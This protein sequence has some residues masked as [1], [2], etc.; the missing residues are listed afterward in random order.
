M[1]VD[2]FVRLTA[3]K[4]ADLAS[5][6]PGKGASLVALPHGG[7]L[8]D[9][10]GTVRDAVFATAT[11]SV[12]AAHA[13][14]LATGKTRILVNGLDWVADGSLT[15]FALPIEFLGGATCSANGFLLTFTQGFRADDYAAV[16]SPADAALLR[17][18]AWQRL[19][20]FHFGAKA[21]FVSA[22]TPGT[23]DGPA[24][25]AWAS[26]L[27]TRFMPAGRYGTTQTIHWNGN[28]PA[29]VNF[30][31]QCDPQAMIFQRTDN[32]PVMT[33]YGSR[34]EWDFPIL[35]YATSQSTSNFGAVGLLIAPY[36]GT[37]G[38]Y[39]NIIGRIM[40]R[41]GANTGFFNPPAFA[42]TLV[43]TA[44][45]NATSAIVAHAQTDALGG[46]PWV[47]GMWVQLQLDTGSWR[48]TRCTSVTSASFATTL[49]AG[50]ATSATSIQ[51]TNATGWTTG[52]G[53]LITLDTGATFTT[54]ITSVAG[55]TIGLATALP[56]AAAATRVAVAGQT[57][58]GFNSALPSAAAAGRPIQ[59]TSLSSPS[60]MPSAI[61]SN[62][63]HNV[64]IDQPTRYGFIDRGTGTGDA[65]AQMYVRT[66]GTPGDVSTPPVTIERAV[67]I[68]G[69]RASSITQF[70]IEYLGF[71][72]DAVFLSGDH[73]KLGEVH[74]EGCRSYG[75][76]TGLISGTVTDM[77][78][79]LLQVEYW[80]AFTADIATS[81]GIMCP[82]SASGSAL[83][84]TRGQWRIRQLHTAKNI[85][86]NAPPGGRA[87]LV[88]AA[89]SA[90]LTQVKIDTWRYDRD[91]GF[92]PTGQLCT[93]SNQAGLVSISNLL[94]PDCVAF[95]FDLDASSDSAANYQ[96]IY[97]SPKGQ[98]KVREVLAFHPSV[99]LTTASCGVFA[100]N[101]GTTLISS[102][103]NQAL[104]ALTDT[105]KVLSIPLASAEATTLRA[106]A[107]DM[108]FKTNV[109][110]N[111]PAAVTGSS[112]YLTGR[113][114]GGGNTNLA[115]VNFA[116]PHGFNVGD[117][118]FISGS[119]NTALS[120]GKRKIVDVPST[121]QITVY[122][123]SAVA[124]G[125]AAAPVA[126]AAIT[127][128]R[129]PTVH[130]VVTGTD[131]GH[132]NAC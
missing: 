48:I 38:W 89:S 111:K 50:A 102:V 4:T 121:T 88:R 60:T 47:P 78:I 87:F 75:D 13:L 7:T 93:N 77:D 41:G 95:A 54:T 31:M 52:Q 74:I 66:S 101:T 17:L 122:C 35:E 94:P 117:V 58:L 27:C 127:V 42:S 82:R 19:T 39:Q 62:T 119:V 44:A 14:A 2:A 67:Y 33:C 36:P 113:N 6:A 86:N 79:D 81:V 112:S 120:A 22:A 83:G 84:S 40:V 80:T 37:T 24:L 105:G 114:G 28:L 115:F 73:F 68:T 18:P 132:F 109:A 125:S 45:A 103:N 92:Y 29:N 130:V 55:T 34:G 72:K 9:L 91:G 97:A 15:T 90:N 1:A 53:V 128:Q 100:D 107:G 25:N 8:G 21:D 76:Q 23:D 65:I 110:Q 59:V 70:N 46:Y 129:M 10:G 12:E 3:A 20:P 131:I 26:E 96:R 106:A 11:T 32:I 16:F 30:G 118:V 63:I 71:T 123:D 56:S 126:D 5:S 57:T 61:F 85:I 51:V 99:S 69:K 98:Y 104:A 49:A 116:A 108:F 64:T 124:V 43:S